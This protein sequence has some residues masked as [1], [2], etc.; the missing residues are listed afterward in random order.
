MMRLYNK[1]FGNL[2]RLVRKTRYETLI[3]PTLDNK[4]VIMEFLFSDCISTLRRARYNLAQGL[5][6]TSVSLSTL[7]EISQVCL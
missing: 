1:I 3:K 2:G 5:A 7:P 6:C 4:I